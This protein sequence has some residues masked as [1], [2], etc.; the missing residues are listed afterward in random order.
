MT[1]LN[2]GKLFWWFYHADTK[3]VIFFWFRCLICLN[4]FQH[5]FVL[6]ILEVWLIVCLESR[7]LILFFSFTSSSSP[8]IGG[9]SDKPWSSHFCPLSFI[10]SAIVFSGCVL[11]FSSSF[12]YHSSYLQPL[13]NKLLGPFF[14]LS[15][16]FLHL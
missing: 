1:W 3:D 15:F 2:W 12:L 16:F 6:R 7:F 10:L 4:Y 5:L 14:Y 9:M 11:L 13:R 8:S